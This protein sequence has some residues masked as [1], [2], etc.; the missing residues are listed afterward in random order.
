M[1]E[2]R[3]IYNAACAQ[4]AAALA[5]DG[6]EY[7]HSKHVLARG[8][9]DLTRE[10][11]FQSSF[12]NFTLPEQGAG[13]VQKAVSLLPLIGETTAFGSVTLIAHTG[14]HSKAFKLWR[15]LQRQPLSRRMR[16]ACFRADDA[17]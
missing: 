6:L 3:N 8:D 14:V 7:R 17:I 4:I 15:A 1:G 12:R 10:I 5:Q 16:A 13:F 11:T 2:A 9:G